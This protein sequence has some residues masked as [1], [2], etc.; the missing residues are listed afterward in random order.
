[1]VDVHEPRKSISSERTFFENIDSDEE[2]EDRL[3]TLAISVAGTLR[4]SGLRARTVTVKLRSATFTNR[5]AS[6]TL[7]VPLDSDAALFQVGRGL[8]AQLRNK[9]RGPVRLMGIGVT[10]LAPPGGEGQLRL[11]EPEGG[12]ED[13]RARRVTAAVDALRAKFGKSAILPGRIASKRKPEPDLDGR[14]R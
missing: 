6:R 8:L 14:N 5:S 10:G 3:F 13:E 11:F 1:M 7:D 9:R 2:L 4:K 12:A